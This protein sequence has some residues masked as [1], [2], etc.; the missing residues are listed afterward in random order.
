MFIIIFAGKSGG[1]VRVINSRSAE[2]ALLKDFTGRVID[3]AFAHTDEVMLAAVDEVGNLFVYEIE[4]NEDRKL[5]YP[6]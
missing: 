4:E 3:I 6:F 2:R 1:I 5:V